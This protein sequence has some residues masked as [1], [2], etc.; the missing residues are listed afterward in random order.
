MNR[1]MIDGNIKPLF[2]KLEETGILLDEEKLVSLIRGSQKQLAEQ[3]QRI[4][5]EVGFIVN[6]H[7]ADHWNRVIGGVRVENS[8]LLERLL[9]ARRIS[10]LIHRLQQI[11]DLANG[12]HRVLGRRFGL[13]PRYGFDSDRG[14]TTISELSIGDFPGE[15]LEVVGCSGMSR[16]KATYLEISLDDVRKLSGDPWIA[17]ATVMDLMKLGFINLFE[18]YRVGKLGASIFAVAPC[19]V[20]LFAPEDHVDNVLSVCREC[21]EN[22]H[23]DFI[24]PVEVATER[25]LKKSE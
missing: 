23:A 8:L 10:S 17:E 14:I 9:E 3:K 25:P 2:Q 20:Y 19:L 21:L 22:V 7:S 4:N 1:K 15:V 11:Y 5:R 18:D 6:L 12:N 16:I 24:L 13:Y